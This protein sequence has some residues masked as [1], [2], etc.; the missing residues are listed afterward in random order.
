MPV[1]RADMPRDQAVADAERQVRDDDGQIPVFGE[2]LLP[3]GVEDLGDRGGGD[4]EPVDREV[5]TPV[6]R[7]VLMNSGR[8]LS[9][10]TSIRS[11][12]SFSNG[13]VLR[14]CR[15]IRSAPR[16]EVMITTEC[17]KSTVRPWAAEGS[18]PNAEIYANGCLDARRATA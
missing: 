3:R 10:R 6:D 16:F 12:F 13:S 9:R 17:L 8:K 2:Q 15:W 7:P 14:A 5:G 11:A 18:Y 4:D 1:R